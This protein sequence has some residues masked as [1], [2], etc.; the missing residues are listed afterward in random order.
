MCKIEYILTYTCI[1][2]MMA[3]C[4]KGTTFQI[5]YR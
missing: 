4:N 3:A 5:S 1:R 2:Q